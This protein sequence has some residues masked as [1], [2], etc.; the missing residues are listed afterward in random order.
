MREL[1]PASA[2]IV[3]DPQHHRIDAN[4][5]PGDAPRFES[6]QRKLLSD[7][8]RRRGLTD[9]DDVPAAYGSGGQT[10]RNHRH[11]PAYSYYGR[12]RRKP[13]DILKNRAKGGPLPNQ[14]FV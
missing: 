1:N 9:A 6:A 4:V 3:A 11:R 2:G 13:A 12:K 5:A 14:V 7:S 8:R 10:N